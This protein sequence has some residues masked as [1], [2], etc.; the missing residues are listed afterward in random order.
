I[1]A[2]FFDAVCAKYLLQEREVRQLVHAACHLDLS[3][4]LRMLRRVPPS[5]TLGTALAAIDPAVIPG[6]DPLQWA[7]VQ[8]ETV[9]FMELDELESWMADQQSERIARADAAVEGLA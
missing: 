3:R 9:M 5:S 8:A 6:L 1:V 7:I 2:A 4:T